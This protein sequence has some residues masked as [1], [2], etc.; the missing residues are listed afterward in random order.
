[1]VMQEL[2][3]TFRSILAPPP[4]EGLQ[5]EPSVLAAVGSWWGGEGSGP[6]LMP[7]SSSQYMAFF[8]FNNRL[9]SILS[10]AY[11]YR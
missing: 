2:G 9:E 3:H 1:M 10:K 8:E 7:C 6:P 5:K 4:T 11:V